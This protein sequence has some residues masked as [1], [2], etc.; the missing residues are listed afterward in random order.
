MSN[1]FLKLKIEFSGGLELLF[2]N[3][4]SHSIQIPSV[5]PSDNNSPSVVAI[6][7][8]SSLEAGDSV[9]DAKSAVSQ[10]PQVT[11]TKPADISY[12]LCY[13]R[14]HLLKER[15]ELFMESGTV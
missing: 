8:L 10:L 11:K 13:L 9:S 12:L 4:R 2:S 1:R 14:D 7:S 3:Q 6:P 5:V 15:L